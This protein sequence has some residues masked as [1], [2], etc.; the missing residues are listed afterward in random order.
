MDITASTRFT[1]KNGKTY[2][3]ADR[4]TWVSNG[5]EIAMV[6]L[7]KDGVTTNFTRNMPVADIRAAI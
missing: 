3:V 2:E 1:A 5:R 4:S 6:H 7:V